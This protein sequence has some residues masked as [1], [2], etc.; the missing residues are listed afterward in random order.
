MKYLEEYLKE[1]LKIKVL[2]EL[3]T[4]E[5]EVEPCMPIGERL[6]ID[7][8]ESDIVVW[9]SDYSKWLEDKLYENSSGFLIA[10]R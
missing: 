1:R 10:R 2:G 6:V 4:V 7:G 5:E 8:R 3:T 9:F